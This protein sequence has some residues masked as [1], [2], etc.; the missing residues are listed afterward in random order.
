MA[1]GVREQWEFICKLNTDFFI[2]Q[3]KGFTPEQLDKI[4]ALCEPFKKIGEDLEALTNESQPHEP[5]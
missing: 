1:Q 5:R 4:R 2:S 3:L